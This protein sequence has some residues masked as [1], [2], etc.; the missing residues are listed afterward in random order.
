MLQP[1]P[2]PFCSARFVVCLHL[3]LSLS[4]RLPLCSQL[5][6]FSLL[7]RLS[8]ESQ[9]SSLLSPL[10]YSCFRSMAEH[11]HWAGRESG[12]H[13]KPKRRSGVLMN[14]RENSAL[15]HKLNGIVEAL[16]RDLWLLGAVA[17][18]SLAVEW[19]SAWCRN[20]W[21]SKRSGWLGSFLRALS[22]ALK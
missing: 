17:G 18:L 12:F 15:P 21:S 1:L 4:T 8:E 5:R 19:I 14:Q 16:T 13:L 11:C 22:V 9:S 3:P 6:S 7:L 20:C 10:P 2:S